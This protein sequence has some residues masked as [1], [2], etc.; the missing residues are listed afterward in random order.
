MRLSPRGRRVRLRRPANRDGSFGGL[1]RMKLA[2][3]SRLPLHDLTDRRPIF[4]N[5]C[6]E[7]QPPLAMGL[8]RLLHPELEP[9]DMFLSRV[10]A[11]QA[12]EGGSLRACFSEAIF[13]RENRWPRRRRSSRGDTAGCRIRLPSLLERSRLRNGTRTVER[14]TEAAFLRSQFQLQ[15]AHYRKFY[16]DAAYQR[17]PPQR[18][19][20]PHVCGPNFHRDPANG[21]HT[22]CRSTATRELAESWCG[23]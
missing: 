21:D 3:F 17:G 11:P 6:A 4:H 1:V 19:H 7:G 16:P 23:P 5:F 10:M 20:R 2:S 18:G 15:Y 8:H 14:G 13:N 12:A 9:F 22:F